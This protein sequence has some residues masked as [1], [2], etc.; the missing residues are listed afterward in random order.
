[1]SACSTLPVFLQVGQL[2]VWPSPRRGYTKNMYCAISVASVFS[3]VSEI[4]LNRRMAGRLE[5]MGLRARRHSV[6]YGP[7]AHCHQHGQAEHIVI[8]RRVC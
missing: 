7:Q 3:K 6:A 8:V 2:T 1:M 5:Q 4:L